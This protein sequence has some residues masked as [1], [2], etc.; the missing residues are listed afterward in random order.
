VLVSDEGADCLDAPT[1]AL[2]IPL[3]TQHYLLLQRNLVYTRAT[4]GKRLV[5][6]VG[7]KKALAI[8]VRNNKTDKPV[9]GAAGEVAHERLMPARDRVPGPPQILRQIH[10]HPA[11]RGVR[12]VPA[13]PSG[14]METVFVF[15]H[16]A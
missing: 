15:L 12:K 1:S 11:C 3:A 14:D 16:I 8:A 6:L 13:G 10:F 7:Q 9:F 5:V 2:V 4:R